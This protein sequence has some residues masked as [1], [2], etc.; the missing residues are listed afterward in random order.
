MTDSYPFDSSQWQYFGSEFGKALPTNKKP[1][2]NSL[3]RAFLGVD[4][5]MPNANQ[6]EFDANTILSEFAKNN[7]LTMRDSTCRALT[8][9]GISMRDPAA[10]TG[11]GWWLTSNPNVPSIGSYGVRNGPMNTN[12][13]KEIGAG[14]WIWDTESAYQ[15]EGEKVSKK[16]K[17]CKDL[18]YY[19]QFPNIGWCNSMNRAILTDG[20]GRPAYPRT[21]AGF[22]P[23][24]EK[25]T[26]SS[27]DCPI[28]KI[29]SNGISGG[30]GGG[31]SIVP[32]GAISDICQPGGNGLLTNNCLQSLTNSV[33][34]ERGT[35]YKSFNGGFPATIPSF[36]DT[37]SYL[38][39]R[40]FTLHP[41]IIKDGN[42]T[43][44]IAL[45]SLKGLRQYADSGETNLAAAAAANL[46]YGS[47]FSPCIIPDSKLPPFDPTCVKRAML[48]IGFKSSGAL[49]SADISTWNSLSN[50]RAVLDK[51]TWWK[52]L[53]DKGPSFYGMPQD[54]GQA[55]KNV[56]GV[57]VNYPTFPPFTI[58]GNYKMNTTGGITYYTITDST[59][60][61]VNGDMSK[62]GI[63]A[64]GGGGWGGYKC[65]GGGGGVQ[66]N[67]PNLA[68][69]SQYTPLNMVS[70]NT[71]TVTIGEGG[72]LKRNSEGTQNNGG[73]TIIT[74]PGVDIRAI[75]GAASGYSGQWCGSTSGG[76][77][78][79]GVCEMNAGGLQGGSTNTPT[80]LGSDAGAGAG[81]NATSYYN[82][83]P[84]I[85]VNGVEYG[86]A[87]QTV[88]LTVPQ[89]YTALPNTGGGGANCIS[90][91]GKAGNGGSG[92]VILM[93][94][95]P[96]L[97]A[98]PPPPIE[99]FTGNMSLGDVGMPPGHIYPN[100]ASIILSTSWI[101]PGTSAI[102]VIQYRMNAGKK[103]N[104]TV[105][106]NTGKTVV[107]PVL[108]LVNPPEQS[109]YTVVETPDNMLAAF[110]P[111]QTQTLRISL[112]EAV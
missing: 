57:S 60:I 70:C 8:Y 91:D 43:T 75:G 96:I 38:M 80:T 36:N 101:S 44:N 28:P 3:E 103:Y 40:G 79:G 53:A 102:K 58:A 39:Q 98:A 66:T 15:Q 19:T 84:G 65:G 49:Y 21:E 76:C 100:T 63:F 83:G 34:G 17:S 31:G 77:S 97:N 6:R 110:P 55:V 64:V 12:L 92:V 88:G 9:P 37:N 25:I 16:I 68:F 24:G 112:A 33:C 99:L 46:C 86:A 59:T 7:D 45:E 108:K 48:S 73:D 93:T 111:A 32:K 50:W 30:G 23:D 69:R 106:S 4:P 22:C 14:K 47:P 94:G 109:F 81:G 35:L 20:N 78:A 62:V 72:K 82:G 10:T 61:L 1:D 90:Y 51:L 27:G 74:G 54:Q 71:Y 11:C 67:T 29:I 89:P 18:D 56:Y 5:N 104:M 41:G 85:K 105:T 26:M 87:V 2:N 42:I 52:N 95:G 13:E 107:T